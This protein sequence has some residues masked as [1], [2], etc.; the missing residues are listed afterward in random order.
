MAPSTSWQQLNARQRTY[1]QALYTCDQAT[2][3]DRRRAAAN[4]FWDRTLASEWR[5]QMYGPVAP[6]ST[7]YTLLRQAKLVDPG[8]GSTWKALEERG[9]VETGT[10]P[11]AFGVPLLRA[12]VGTLSRAVPSR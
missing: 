9:L 1:L 7:L 11:D 6:P 8:T 5:R 4:G 12:R 2:E 10:V 3:A